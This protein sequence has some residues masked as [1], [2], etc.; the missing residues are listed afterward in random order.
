[1]KD[2]TKSYI[3]TI[4]CLH[5]LTISNVAVHGT[6]TGEVTILSPPAVQQ[7]D[8]KGAYPLHTQF[9]KLIQMIQYRVLIGE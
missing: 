2:H 3:H 5:L 4:Q 8:L 9:F 1:M 6:R 7:Q